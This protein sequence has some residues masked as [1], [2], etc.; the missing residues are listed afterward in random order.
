MDLQRRNLLRGKVGTPKQPI[1]LPWLTDA[2]QFSDGC[3][4]CEKCI[5]SCKENII[6]K[7]DGGFPEINFTLGECTFCGA[8]SNVCPEPLFIINN[9]Q[10]PWDYHATVNNKCLTYNNISCQSCQDSC[11]PMAIRFQYAIGKPPSPEI[12]TESCTGCGACVATCPSQ[13][14]EIKSPTP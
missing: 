14:I 13:A 2:D 5:T 4:Q 1:R 8:C 11:E 7:G 10:A 12:N 9:G 6:V 3:T